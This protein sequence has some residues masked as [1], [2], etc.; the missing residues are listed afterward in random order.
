MAYRG[1]V[2]KDSVTERGH[3]LTSFEVEMPRIVLAEYNT[4][5]VLSRN[6]ASSRAIPVRKQIKKVLADPFV[7]DI[8]G[9]NMSGMSPDLDRPLTEQEL[10]TATTHWLEARDAAVEH[11]IKLLLGE[12]VMSKVCKDQTGKTWSKTGRRSRFESLC[13][14]VDAMP[15]DLANQEQVDEALGVSVDELLNIHKQYPNRLLEPFMWHTIITTGTEWSNFFALRTDTNAQREIRLAA[16]AMQDAHNASEPVLLS[17]DE[18][19]LP[20]FDASNEV[21]AGVLNRS[22][23]E[24]KLVSIGRCARVSYL[25]HFGLRDPAEDIRLASGLAANGHMSPFEHVARPMTH[26][27][28]EESEFLGNFRGWVQARK[29]IPNEDDFARAMA[30]RN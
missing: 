25:T 13:A 20:L 2:L 17:Q 23:E 6:S 8:F 30:S 26:E 22:V 24:A 5:R 9:R 29:E 19:H 21:D 11:A 1:L 4:H 27:E 18:W 15:A 7:P 3:R 16:I 10:E 12:R 28:M 14:I